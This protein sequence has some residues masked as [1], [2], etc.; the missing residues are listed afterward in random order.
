MCHRPLS[1][2]IVGWLAKKGSPVWGIV[3]GIPSPW[4]HPS[5]PLPH[6]HIH[7][8][9]HW[10]SITRD[11]SK[12]LTIGYNHVG[13]FFN[14]VGSPVEES[15]RPSS[16]ASQA[17]AISRLQSTMN[18]NKNLKFLVD[19]CNCSQKTGREATFQ[20]KIVV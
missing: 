1:H 16:Y 3:K 2:D 7:S 13:R 14:T 12:I 20:G 9:L 15:V 4:C 5:L 8:N 6:F 19:L 10:N 18:S 11:F 17:F